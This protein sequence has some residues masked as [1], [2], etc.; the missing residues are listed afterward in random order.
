MDSAVQNN[1]LTIYKHRADEVLARVLDENLCSSDHTL[2]ELH[3]AMRYAV[4]NG[5]KRVRP[6]LCYATARALGIPQ[7][8]LDVPAAAIEIMHAYSLVH[9]DLPAMDDDDL[10]RGLPTCHKRYGEATAI[11]AGDALQALSFTAL[12]NNQDP[13]LDAQTRN[14]MVTLLGLASGASGMAAGQAIDLAA[15]G[16][17]LS[18]EE[19]QNMH[20]HKTGKLIRASIKI[21]TLADRTI[22]SQLVQRL[23]NFADDIGLLFQIVDDILDVISDTE[24]LGKTQGADN[25]LNKP[26][27]PA[28]LGLAGARKHAVETY[29]QAQQ[30]LDGLGHEFDELRQISTFIIERTY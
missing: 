9:D 18:L 10:R 19:L 21:A 25:M 20:R 6:T 7:Q 23:D 4:I 28:L 12:A 22:E 15:V 16:K 17:A 30:H 1:F 3:D 27:Y 8:T 11:L 14:D 13:T 26:T 5:G 29:Q 24:T 2:Q